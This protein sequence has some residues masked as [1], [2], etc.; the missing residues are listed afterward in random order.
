M[1][2]NPLIMSSIIFLVLTKFSY[3]I[4]SFP[5]LIISFSPKDNPNTFTFGT[6]LFFFVCLFKDLPSPDQVSERTCLR[7]SGV[8]LPELPED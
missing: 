4:I 2:E 1:L 6:I 7:Y 5:S 8:I 3:F